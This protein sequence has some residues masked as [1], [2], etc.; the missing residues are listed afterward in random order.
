MKGEL[1]QGLS[2]DELEALADCNLAPSAQAHLDDL[3][4]RHQDG[5]LLPAEISELDALLQRTDQ[6][7]LI[8]AR[9]RFTL[10]QSNQAVTRQ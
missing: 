9:A 1:L 2:F 3:L 10:S 4:A 8:K 7:T 5:K 6:L